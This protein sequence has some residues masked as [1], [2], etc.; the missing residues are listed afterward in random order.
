MFLLPRLCGECLQFFIRD[1]SLSTVYE[2]TWQ[3]CDT[4]VRYFPA[5]CHCSFKIENNTAVM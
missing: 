5:M 1:D 3:S 2:V 4:C